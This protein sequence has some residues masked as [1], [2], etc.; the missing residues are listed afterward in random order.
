MPYPPIIPS[1]AQN[2]SCGLNQSAAFQIHQN[3]NYYRRRF[4]SI[5]PSPSNAIVAGSGTDES[6][7]YHNKSTL[8]NPSSLITVRL[9]SP[10]PFTVKNEY[11]LTSTPPGITGSMPNNSNQY[12]GTKSRYRQVPVGGYNRNTWLNNRI[13]VSTFKRTRLT[14]GTPRNTV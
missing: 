12:P 2:K 13:I 9:T 14:F 11:Y 7:G 3:I 5:A 10:R 6:S 1:S 4:N 8:S